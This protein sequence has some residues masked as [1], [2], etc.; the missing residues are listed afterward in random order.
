[1]EE[2][3]EVTSPANAATDTTGI[4]ATLRAAREALGASVEEAA[5]RTRIRPEYLRALEDE[6]FDACGHLAHARAHL[7][8]YARFLSLDAAAMVRDYTKRVEGS[9]PS[10]IE[11][12][13]ER[14][15]SAK[16]PP[17]PNWLIAGLVAAALLIA[18]SLTGIVRGPGP[19]TASSGNGNALPT[20]PASST[21]PNGLAS[22]PAA[23]AASPITLVVVAQGRTWVRALADG[24]LVFEGSLDRGASRTINGTDAIDLTVS[25]AGMV[26][27]ILN[28]RDLGRPGKAG[29]VYRARLGPR[30][31]IPAK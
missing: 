10:P 25:N 22:A 23:A 21:Q 13:D 1:L 20:L 30:G 28:G 31:P 14:D 11:H 24:T 29:D 7:H 4:G 27:L 26:R 15:R 16:R 12:L 3:R 19:R 2:S 17:K 6:R 18:A 5:W 8:S 9:E